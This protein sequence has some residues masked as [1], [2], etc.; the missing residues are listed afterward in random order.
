MTEYPRCLDL[1]EQTRTRS[2]LLFGPR[3]TGKTFLLRKT[4]PES[5]FCSLLHSGQFLRLSARPSLLRE[6][7]LATPP[8]G[9]TPVIIDEV[10]KLP[11]LLDEVQDLIETR[12]I[13]FILSGSSA[14][15]LVRQGSNLLGGRGQRDG[16]RV[17]EAPE[18]AARP[19][20]GAPARE[21]G[22]GF[23]GRQA[24]N[25]RRRA[26]PALAGIPFAPLGWGAVR[27]G[28]GGRLGLRPARGRYGGA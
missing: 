6:E 25:R 11:I 24:A 21:I 12:G 9:A 5:P 17:R 8:A 15:K 1:A 23:P 26:D 4:F 27:R 16:E 19:G 18:G 3:Q 10:Q 2:I 7:L 13:R 20:R 28:P 22:R 14:R